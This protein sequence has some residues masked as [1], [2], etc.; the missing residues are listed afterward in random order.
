MEE[1]TILSAFSMFHIESALRLLLA[2]LCGAALGWERERHAKPAGL[3]THMMVSLGAATFL[4]AGMHYMESLGQAEPD[5]MQ[6]D[7]FRIISGIIGGVGFLGAGSIIEARGDVRGLT[8]AASI[9]LAAAT[10]VTCGMGYYGLGIMAVGF[11]MITLVVVGTFEKF[12]F[13]SKEKPED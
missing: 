7:L 6:A 5:W 1:V 10:G 8:T 3:R 9:W 12:Y 2:T 11:A 4:L 13:A